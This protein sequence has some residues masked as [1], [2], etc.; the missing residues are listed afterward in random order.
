[1]ISIIIQI[2]WTVG[3]IILR[4]LISIYFDLPISYIL[5]RMIGTSFLNFIAYFMFGIYICKNYN[6]I[7][8]IFRPKKNYIILTSIIIL[9]ILININFS[10]I[11]F[12]QYTSSPFL[13]EINQLIKD[14]IGLFFYS[15]IT[16]FLLKLSIDLRDQKEIFEKILSKFGK[17]SFGIYLIH[18]AIRYF[19]IALLN[20][21]HINYEYWYF[22][23]ICFIIVASGSLFITFL[24]SFLPH[25][26]IL[27]GNFKRLKTIE[28]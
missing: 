26:E 2:I 8:R 3:R 9:F 27:I 15:F 6:R 16:I 28:L 10:I 23:I 4:D 1:M 12:E 17:Y 25:H 18:M 11:W 24:I 5:Q 19:T 22:Y 21:F 13:P 20:L 7:I 14:L